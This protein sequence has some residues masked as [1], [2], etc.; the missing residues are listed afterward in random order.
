[1]IAL[2]VNGVLYVVTAGCPWRDMSADYRS[3]FTA[4]RRNSRGR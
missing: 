1:M 4:W 2:F 3:Y